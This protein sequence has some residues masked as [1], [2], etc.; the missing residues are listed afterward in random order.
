MKDDASTTIKGGK[1]AHVIRRLIH[2]GMLA[3]PFIYFYALVPYFP[4][5]II[6]IGIL[7]FVFFVFLFEKLRIR[8]RLVMFGQRLN[9]ASRVSSFAW[10]MLS[11]AIILFFVPVHFAI[12]LVATCA[13][14][15][16][17]MG[18]LR[19]H[20]VNKKIVIACGILCAFVIWFTCAFIYHFSFWI[21]I[22]PALI[23]VVIEQPNLKWI[24]DNALMLLVPMLVVLI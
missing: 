23:A 21:G 12:P 20:Q 7:A 19:L 17:L 1:I 11:I 2:V 5:K 22:L 18:E 16:P 8:T 3:I 24:D 4:Q 13:F 9:E 15:D 14:V 6:H 10:T